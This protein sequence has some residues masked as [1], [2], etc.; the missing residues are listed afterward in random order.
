ML[1]VDPRVEEVERRRRNGQRASELGGILV[2]DEEQVYA[3][4]QGALVTIREQSLL[5][6]RDLGRTLDNEHARAPP[7]PV[8]PAEHLLLEAFHVDL[9]EIDDAVADV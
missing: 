3:V 5:P 1:D 9:Q 7:G 6:A 8:E 4:P 2:A